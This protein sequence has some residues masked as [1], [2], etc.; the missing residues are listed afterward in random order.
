MRYL[1]I[2][3]CGILILG[4]SSHVTRFYYLNAHHPV[5]YDYHLPIHIKVVLP[6]YLNQ[7]K[8]ISRRNTH[9]IGINENAVW[10]TPLAADITAIIKQALI[11]Q[12]AQKQKLQKEAELSVY[13]KQFDCTAVL[14]QIAG[15]WHMTMTDTSGTVQPFAYQQ[16]V[17]KDT[18]QQV[19]TLNHLT[20]QMAK[21]IAQKMSL[22]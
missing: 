2:C 21:D 1:L 11:Q 16:A 9:E 7:E 5:V 13:F 3:C 12:Q 10:A 18:H 8:I 17:S 22:K 4:C 20:S 14:C 6:Q 19:V 15:T